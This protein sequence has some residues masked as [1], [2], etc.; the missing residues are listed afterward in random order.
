MTAG[1]VLLAYALLLGADTFQIGLLSTA[2]MAGASLQLLSDAL[3]RRLRTRKRLGIV[4]LAVTAAGRLL[5]GLL[6]AM[7]AWVAFDTLPWALLAGLVIISGSGQTAEIARLSWIAD[8]VP[9]ERRGRFL[10]DRQFVVQLVGSMAAIVAAWVMDW[11]GT[12]SPEHATA[13]GQGLFILAA[14]LGIGSIL[15]LR[16]VPEP[17]IA[18]RPRA[19]GLG[20]VMQPVRDK[21]FRPIMVYTALWNLAAPLCGPFFNLYLIAVLQMPLG[22]VAIYSFLGQLA[23]IYSVRLWGK[24]A[25]K[26][27]NLPVLRLCVAAKTIFPLLWVFLWP[28]EGGVERVLMFILAGWVHLWRGFNSGQQLATINLALGAMP[29]DDGTRYL[30][31]FRT[32]GNWI[33]AV[34]PAIGGLIAA[35]LQDVGWSVQWSIAALFMLSAVVRAC[36]LASVHWI[37]EPRAKSLLHVWR[38]L[39]RVRGFT[40]SRGLGAFVRFWGGPVWSGFII[41]RARLGALTA[42]WR[43]FPNGNDD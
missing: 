26:F 35:W 31:A 39:C 40:P 14:V 15:T 21:R 29:A 30:S 36:S 42:Q 25:D 43:G 19:R 23:S 18:T 13:T 22:V 24:L 11:Q 2:Q 6:P 7:A 3:L 10:G 32:L 4:A 33:H 38:A 8:V 20:F 16:S 41:V 12:Y 9:E 34:G 1:V 37:E 17:P 5:L 27:G 28:A